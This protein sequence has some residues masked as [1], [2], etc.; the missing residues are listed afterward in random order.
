MRE[1]IEYMKQHSEDDLKHWNGGICTAQKKWLQ[2]VLESCHDARKQC[3]I[4]CHHPIVRLN[5]LVCIECKYF[6]CITQRCPVKQPLKS[7]LIMCSCVQVAGRPSHRAW[8]AQE[9]EE[10][11]SAHSC[12]VAVLSG[13]DHKGGYMFYNGVHHVVMEAMLESPTDSTAFAVLEVH[14]NHLAIL[15][16]GSVSSRTLNFG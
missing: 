8:G 2:T 5:F 14:Q 12:V 3:I 10:I 11:I 6:Y 13:H 9:L 15:G 7:E 16:S 1:T 4:A